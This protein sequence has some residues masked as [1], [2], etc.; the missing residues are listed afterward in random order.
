MYILFHSDLATENLEAELTIKT[1]ALNAKKIAK[2][3]V[4][5]S[6]DNL[7]HNPYWHLF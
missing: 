2:W 4:T 3:V 6:T 1:H 5:L 7:P